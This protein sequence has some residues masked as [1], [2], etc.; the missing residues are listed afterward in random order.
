MSADAPRTTRSRRW[1][2]SGRK[3]LIER[4]I[5]TGIAVM[6]T[7]CST[8]SPTG[9]RIAI[10]LDPEK[11]GRKGQEKGE[12]HH[13]DRAAQ[14]GESDG[15]RGVAPGDEGDQ[16]R[17]RPF[18]TRGD[19]DES[20]RPDR[21]KR[22]EEGHPK[23]GRRKDQELAPQPDHG[24]PRELHHP[25]EVGHGERH[26]EVY[27][28]DDQ[29]DGQDR[30]DQ[31]ALF[32]RRL[33]ERRWYGGVNHEARFFQGETILRQTAGG[34]GPVSAPAHFPFQDPAP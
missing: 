30:A 11:P 31:D 17:G 6:A 16:V 28:D 1:A 24:G 15:K 19:Q 23:H 2:S 34:R 8:T 13:C 32:Q 27:H 33:R 22:E 9:A 25:S 18:G 4:P 5:V 12:R 7:I 10:G 21:G 26:P 3:C 20:H 14:R 29:G